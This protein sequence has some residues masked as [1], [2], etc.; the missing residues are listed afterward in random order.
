MAE[1]FKAPEWYLREQ[2]VGSNP[3]RSINWGLFF[4]IKHSA[5]DIVA[6]LADN[7]LFPLAESFY[8]SFEFTT[9]NGP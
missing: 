3:A 7:A 6:E 2:V 9:K 5:L 8:T 4:L 1:R